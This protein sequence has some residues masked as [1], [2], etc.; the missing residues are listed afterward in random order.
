MEVAATERQNFSAEMEIFEI[1][2]VQNRDYIQC[3]TLLQRGF[4][5]S[6]EEIK[7]IGE[8]INNGVELPDEAQLLAP[9]SDFH[10]APAETGFE[11]G[12]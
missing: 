8:R 4:D 11:D 9:G 5:L 1:E 10:G 6:I 2:S 7:N 3:I 12:L